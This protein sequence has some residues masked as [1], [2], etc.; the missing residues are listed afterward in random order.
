MII[1]AKASSFARKC[2]KYVNIGSILFLIVII[3]GVALKERAK[4]A[5]WVVQVGPATTVLCFVTMI[6]SYY[7]SRVL[8]TNRPQSISISIGAGFQNSGLALVIA[9]SFLKNAQIAIP[10]AVYTVLMYLFA[11]A[12]A[13]YMNLRYERK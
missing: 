10:P 9:T 12:L 6:V 3:L 8:G 5:D 13:G 7:V 2:E 4:I 11:A 1:K